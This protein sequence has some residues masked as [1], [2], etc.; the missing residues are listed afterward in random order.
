VK[1][2]VKHVTDKDAEQLAFLLL[3]SKIND[4]AVV[5]HEKKARLE[6]I[7]KSI[8]KKLSVIELLGY[9]I[10]FTITSHKTFI[11]KIARKDRDLNEIVYMKL[12]DPKH[13]I[14]AVLLGGWV[15]T[16]GKWYWGQY[17]AIDLSYTRTI[18]EKAVFEFVKKLVQLVI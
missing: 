9:R 10:E 7:V 1:D 16:E 8:V 12:W 4:Y 14:K 6:T 13:R 17:I 11:I 18:D 15:V 5:D 2:V 3:E